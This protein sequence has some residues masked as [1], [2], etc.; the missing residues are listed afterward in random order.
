MEAFKLD[1]VKRFYKK[2]KLKLNHS[3][4]IYNTDTLT[5][6]PKIPENIRISISVKLNSIHRV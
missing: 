4:L 2:G 1:N 6:T 5:Y 3:S